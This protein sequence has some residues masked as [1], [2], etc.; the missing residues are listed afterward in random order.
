MKIIGFSIDK[1]DRFDI[2]NMTDVEKNEAM[3]EDSANTFCYDNIDDFFNDLNDDC[4]DTEN[5]WW[6][7]VNI[8]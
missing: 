2:N 6:V 4:V 3:L 5:N 8:D 1:Y 7:K